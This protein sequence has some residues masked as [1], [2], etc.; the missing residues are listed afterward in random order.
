MSETSLS[1]KS[2]ELVADSS[3]DNVKYYSHKII[4]YY[5]DKPIRFPIFS[6]ET[7][8]LRFFAEKDIE[9]KANQC[10]EYTSKN[11]LY[12]SNYL[13]NFSITSDFMNNRGLKISI[14]FIRSRKKQPLQFVFNNFS[15]Y[16]LK[17]HEHSEICK[18]RFVTH[19][20]IEFETVQDIDLDSS[21]NE[22]S[23]IAETQTT[24]I[25]AVVKSQEIWK[26]EN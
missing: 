2:N 15:K 16:T 23:A 25:P 4:Y 26:K 13:Y 19:S 8:I 11:S 5:I 1:N 17:I 24:T 9:I 10:V 21:N 6:N 14:L 20:N 18:V 3:D 22:Q 7:K 12:L